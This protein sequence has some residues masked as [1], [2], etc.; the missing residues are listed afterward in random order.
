MNHQVI[1]KKRNKTNHLIS[2]VSLFCIMLF[3]CNNFGQELNS[4]SELGVFHFEEEIIDYGT[5]TQNDNGVRTFK[6]TNRGRAPIVISKVKTTCGCT[7]PTYPKQAILPGESGTIDIKYATNRVGTFSKS[8]TIISNADNAQKKLKIK[9]NV[10][11][12]S[13]IAVN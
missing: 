12:K 13:K 5:I 2:L 11:A 3:S 6:F 4:K 1:I 8:I 9:G 7:V 10:T